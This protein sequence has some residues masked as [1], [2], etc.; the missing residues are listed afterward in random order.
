MLPAMDMNYHRT[1]LK[2]RCATSSFKTPP[3]TSPLGNRPCCARVRWVIVGKDQGLC[4]EPRKCSG[5]RTSQWLTHPHWQPSPHPVF[6]ALFSVSSA[7]CVANQEPWHLGLLV[8]RDLAHRSPEV[9]TEMGEDWPVFRQ[10]APLEPRTLLVLARGH[11]QKAAFLGVAASLHWQPRDL[12][13]AEGAGSYWLLGGCCRT[14]WSMIA[15]QRS[16]W[17]DTG[18]QERRKSHLHKASITNHSNNNDKNSPRSSVSLGLKRT[19][20]TFSAFS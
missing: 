10:E 1:V 15:R 17:A 7:H 14:L 4:L 16:F 5:E 9:V 3:Q 13:H 19:E 18:A 2:L 6:R 11:S 12:V 20:L 8:L